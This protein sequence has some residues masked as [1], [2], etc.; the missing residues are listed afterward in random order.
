MSTKE[1][2]NII[3]KTRIAHELN[4]MSIAVAEYLLDNINIVY[5]YCEKIKISRTKV[6]NELKKLEL[7]ARGKQGN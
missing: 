6:L 1:N 4:S 3:S 7:S 5:D 2:M